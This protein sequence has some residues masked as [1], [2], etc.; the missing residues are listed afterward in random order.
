MEVAACDPPRRRAEGDT[1]G[2]RF[3]GGVALVRAAPLG[4]LLEVCDIVTLHVPLSRHGED[5]TWHLADERFFDRLRPG[6]ILINTARGA[7]VDT[8]ALLR[9]MHAGR[10]AHAVIDTWEG[11]PAYPVE[12]LRR[13]DVATPH[14]AGYSF[15]GKVRG[16]EMVYE[17]ACRFLGREPEWTAADSL[18]PSP[19]PRL[20]LDTAGRGDQEVLR[21]AVR[22]VY[23]IEQD[24]ARF[25]GE[26]ARFGPGAERERA[27]HFDAWRRDYPVRREFPI[28][29]LV[30]RGASAALRRKAADLGFRVDQPA[31]GEDS[32]R[33]A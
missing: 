17:A 25:R 14:I 26:A 19:V 7:V 32:S 8:G 4:E 20:E 31:E 2:V 12:L 18:P 15:D 3:R 6:T 33:A 5:A 28:T 9:A 23:D 21:E 24:D 30:L 10:V 1:L 16:T 11:E 29:R 22:A 27:A 13:A